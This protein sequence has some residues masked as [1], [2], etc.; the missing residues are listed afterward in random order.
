M[1]QITG[2]LSLMIVSLCEAKTL[3]Y[4]YSFE[5]PE[6]TM[7]KDKSAVSMGDLPQSIAPGKPILPF[8]PVRI[9]LPPKTHLK[10]VSA[11]RHNITLLPRAENLKIANRQIPYSMI[12]T[13]QRPPTTFENIRLKKNYPEPLSY[14]STQTFHGHRILTAK[15]HPVF[16]TPAKE[17]LTCEKII[18]KVVTQESSSPLPSQIG[19]RNHLNEIKLLVDNPIDPSFDLYSPTRLSGVSKSTYDYLIL[20]LPSLITYT[21]DSS[22]HVFK[23]FL[24]HTYGLKV[25]IISISDA[26]QSLPGLDS[27]ESIRNFIRQEYKNHGIRYVLLAGDSDRYGEPPEIPVRKLYSSINAYTG[28]SWHQ[29]SAFIPSDF[30]YSCLDGSFNGD[31]DDRWGEMNDG[32]DGGDIDFLCE[33][34]VGRWPIDTEEEL[35]RVVKKTILASEHSDRERKVLL[36]GELLFNELNLWG[37]NY[38][39]Q[40]IG[41]CVDHGFTTQGYDGSWHVTRLYDR[42]ERW[43]GEQ[44]KKLIDEGD[45]LMVNHLGHSST[46]S[47]MRLYWSLSFRNQLPYFYYTQG[48]FSGN[49]LADDSITEKMFFGSNGP[50]A[51]VSNSHYGLGPEDPDPQ[52]TETPG[53]SQILHRF[54]INRVLENDFHAFGEAH[55]KSKEDITIYIDQEEAR[56]VTW[57]ANFFGD[58]AL[59]IYE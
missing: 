13:R 47:N 22:L 7:E 44:A 48:C 8:K 9:L 54:F 10:E 5:P 19:A 1:L 58:P 15:I 17:I 16:I 2:L 11:M 52:N 46:Y 38:M 3:F 36:L 55:R 49:F 51:I 23:Y 42:D 35:S 28:G 4:E 14:W 45:F 56:W 53:T 24:E 41:T 18:L 27:A 21:G 6:I 50:F 37:G 32:E 57:A 25:K 20:S 29:I 59:R 26:I 43:S 33:V 31:G 34:T 40:F 39:D 12:P 30:Y